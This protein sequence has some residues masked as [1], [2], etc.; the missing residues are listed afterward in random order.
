MRLYHATGK[1]ELWVVYKWLAFCPA[2]PFLTT[3]LHTKVRVLTVFIYKLLCVQGGYLIAHQDSE[4]HYQQ[5]VLMIQLRSESA[6]S[7]GYKAGGWS[8]VNEVR[9]CAHTQ[10]GIQFWATRYAVLA[11]CSAV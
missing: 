9:V 10:H 8:H 7:F 2:V 1:F 5:P 3:R 4:A 11:D 6:L